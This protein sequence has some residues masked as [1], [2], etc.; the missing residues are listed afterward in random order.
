MD[1]LGGWGRITDATAEIF[2]NNEGRRMGSY[3]EPVQPL[4]TLKTY[5]I[6]Q[7]DSFNLTKY[8]T[9]G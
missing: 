5:T 4:G 7:E 1:F 3:R 6:R 2:Y 9:G 8:K